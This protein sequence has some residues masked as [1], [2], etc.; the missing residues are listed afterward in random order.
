MAMTLIGLASLLAVATLDQVRTIPNAIHMVSYS[1]LAIITVVL[2]I[3][4]SL[5]GMNEVFFIVMLI[6]YIGLN[7]FLY[8]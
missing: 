7:L 3:Y 4:I 2:H 1:A 6:I 5:Y 8:I